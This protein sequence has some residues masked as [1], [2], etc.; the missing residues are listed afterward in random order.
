MLV[1]CVSTCVLL[2]VPHRMHSDMDEG[3]QTGREGGPPPPAVMRVTAP[4]LSGII[5]R[6]DEGVLIAVDR[7]TK[8]G[9]CAAESGE[10]S[11]WVK[12]HGFTLATLVDNPLSS[13][14]A[15]VYNLGRW[16]RASIKLGWLQS[17]ERDLRV[18]EHLGV[19]A[20]SVCTKR[21]GKLCKVEGVVDFF[22]F[23]GHVFA[24]HSNLMSHP[25][26][27]QEWRLLSLQL[28]GTINTDFIQYSK[29]SNR[30]GHT[31]SSTH[32]HSQKQQKAPELKE[33][34]FKKA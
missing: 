21:I 26:N 7:S 25:T 12:G 2:C 33:Q 14:N 3:G 31:H 16:G 17:T 29:L 27:G 1:L 6:P 19:F 22:I 18:R 11:L 32:T 20:E 24:I 15:R 34:K 30:P 10:V 8:Q 4:H 13:L 9:L 23:F 5:V 28:P